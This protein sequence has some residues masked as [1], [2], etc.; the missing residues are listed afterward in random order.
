MTAANSVE[1]SP[2]LYARI[3]G[4]LYLIIILAGLF[5]ELYVRGP[6]VV[7][8]QASATAHNILASETLWRSSFAAEM[9]IG[10]CAIPLLA[11]EYFLLRPVNAAL[12]LVGL[13]FNVSSLTV[14]FVTDIWNYSALIF[15]EPGGYLRTFDTH[16]LEALGYVALRL[17]EQGFGVSLIFF[18]FVLICWGYLVYN[19]VY[20]PKTI[21]VLLIVGGLCY[22]INSFALF[23]APSLADAMFPYILIPSFIAELAFCLYMLVVG[24][25]LPKW[26]E[27]LRLTIT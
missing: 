20:F 4:A 2:K 24:V 13:L 11:I 6:L 21:G 18:G 7:S 27:R 12:A 26:N 10:I 1:A 25:N 8:G 16:Q 22:I 19:A 3:G 23:L 14:E 15:L 5:A 17:H 9:I